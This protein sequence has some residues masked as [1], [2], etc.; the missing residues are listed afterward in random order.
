LP[1]ITGLP[2]QVLGWLDKT[3][4][5]PIVVLMPVITVQREMLYNKRALCNLLLKNR[6]NNKEKSTCVLKKT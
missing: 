4:K 6:D 3:L 1:L 5:L 2:F